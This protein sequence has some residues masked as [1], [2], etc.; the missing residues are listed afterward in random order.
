MVL[1]PLSDSCLMLMFLFEKVLIFFLNAVDKKGGKVIAVQS[2]TCFGW[3][4]WFGSWFRATWLFLALAAMGIP[5]S[6][7]TRTDF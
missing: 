3:G 2:L 5:F 1:W 4:G 7:S 6:F